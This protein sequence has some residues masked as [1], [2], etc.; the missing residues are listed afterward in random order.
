M[1]LTIAI[2][3]IYCGLGITFMVGIIVFT[4]TGSIAVS[5]AVG[6][7]SG[8]WGTVFMVRSED[9]RREEAARRS[10]V[11]QSSQTMVRV[12]APLS[13]SKKH[14]DETAQLVRTFSERVN[15][16]PTSTPEQKAKAA[17]KMELLGA[18]EAKH[19]R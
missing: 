18:L 10:T 14:R 1:N 15:G 8:V 11:S 6:V 9:L 17:R 7:V 16:D 13:W 2:G 3:Y 19:N 12:A 4:L 5:A